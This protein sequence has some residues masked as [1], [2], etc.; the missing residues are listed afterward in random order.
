MSDDITEVS[1]RD[2]WEE[3]VSRNPKLD[4]AA[5]VELKIEQLAQMVTDAFS[6]LALPIVLL[7][8]KTKKC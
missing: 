4:G 6:S 8:A 3:L 2:Y 5:V 1:P 7:T